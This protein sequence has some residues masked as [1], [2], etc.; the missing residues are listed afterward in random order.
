MRRLSLALTLA[1]L[2]ACDGSPETTEPRFYNEITPQELA[3]LLT[4]C[5][6]GEPIVGVNFNVD[7]YQVPGE[8]KPWTLVVVGSGSPAASKCFAGGLQP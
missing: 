1:L 7:T 2:A 6:D 4:T 8:D 5:M 3:K